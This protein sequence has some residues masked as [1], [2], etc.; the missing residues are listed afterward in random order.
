M[1]EFEQVL[2]V[3]A[4]SRRLSRVERHSVQLWHEI[5]IDVSL[6]LFDASFGRFFLRRAVQMLALSQ[7]DRGAR[8]FKNA[9]GLVHL[10]NLVDLHRFVLL[11]HLD[12]HVEVLVRQDRDWIL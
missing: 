4:L 12:H 11:L 9:G 7:V 1:L 5:V 6:G 3:G 10:G 8:N 2:R